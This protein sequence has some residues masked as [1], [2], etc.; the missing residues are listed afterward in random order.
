VTGFRVKHLISSWRIRGNSGSAAIEFA[1]VAPVFFTLLF[2]IIEGGIIFFGQ[3][4]VMNATQDA[5][6]LIRTGQAQGGAI[7]ATTFKNKICAGI[8]G[9][10][11]NC[12]THLQV[13]VQ[14]YPAGF[15]PN[16]SSPTDANGN[17]DPALI[18]YNTGGPCDVVI[19]RAFYTYNI[20]TPLV[21]SFLGGNANGLKYLTGA[22][23]FRNEPYGAN[24]C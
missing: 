19:V 7:D 6:R 14:N 17:L 16:Q 12:S 8:S 22:A 11:S 20:V 15:S 24:A 21:K 1:F 18:R 13:D 10:F 2:G 4:A 23:A 9:L 5:A 3:A